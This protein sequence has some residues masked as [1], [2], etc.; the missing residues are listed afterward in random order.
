MR[1][2]SRNEPADYLNALKGLADELRPGHPRT[3]DRAAIIA[4]T[5]SHSKKKLGITRRSA[6]LLSTRPLPG[7]RADPR[8]GP[9]CVLCGVRWRGAN[10]ICQVAGEIGLLESEQRRGR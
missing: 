4:A 5:L 6:Q 3:E 10:C 8:S 7:S 1:V 9:G 2:R